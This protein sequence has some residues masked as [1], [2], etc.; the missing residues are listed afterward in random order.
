MIY[1]AHKCYILLAISM[2]MRK[3]GTLLRVNLSRESI[4]VENIPEYVM[5]AYPGGKALGYYIIAKEVSPSVSALSPENKLVFLPG[6]LSGLAPGASKVAVVSKSPE[7]HLLHDSYAGDRFGPFLKRWGYDAV[8]IEGRAKEL[9]YLQIGAEVKIKSA[10]E[11]SGMGLYSTTEQIWLKHG[12]GA[13]AAIGPGG[14]NLVKFA[15]IM[16][17]TERSAGRGGLGAVMGSKNLKAV[18]VEII[19][20]DNMK[21]APAEP[22]QWNKLRERLYD[23]LGTRAS[24]GLKMYGT[25]NALV[26]SGKHGMSPAYN[27]SRPYIDESLSKGLSG[28][29]VKQYEIA[30]ER[31]IH[32]ASC[33]VKCARYVELAHE[34]ERFRVKPEY[35]SLGMLGAATGVFEFEKVAYLIHLANDL[36][37]D[38]IAAGNVIG[39]L[40]EL[41]ERGDIGA[42]E[43]GIDCTGFGD[44]EAERKLLIYIAF[45]RGIGAVLAEGV[46]RAAEQLNRG[47]DIAVHVKGLEAPAWD[48]RGLRTYALSYATADVG[49]SHLR[50]WPS[51]RSLPNDGPAKELVKSLI[52]A[53]DKDAL[54][55]TLGICKF[56]PYELED[57]RAL[58]Y[59][60][61]GADID[62]NI[63]WRVET[64]SRL[65]AVLAGM[66]PMRDD[67]I[68]QRWW[69]PE[70]EGPAKGNA[71]FINMADF[72]EAK[73][74][75]YRLRE[76]SDKGV[77]TQD[78]LTMLHME[79][80]LPLLEQVNSMA[81]RWS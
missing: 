3:S 67:T 63:G 76:W 5:Q 40:F 57:I 58:Y 9:V 7:T 61:Y 79:E 33:P 70:P 53:R 17:D 44:A 55:D 68:P 77:P 20:L 21:L 73:A 24:P 50:G 25:T 19:A 37:L 10:E 41:V 4:T 81:E 16:F 23:L 52:D 78:T 14:E 2:P 48:P 46:M 6:A 27:F 45:R 59:S 56:V 26:S 43:L 75:F 8:V 54:F 69:E 65:Y 38:A 15:N 49:A 72:L 66:V 39:W 80:H 29:R 34:G 31:F 36:G 30:P 60:V 22:E 11:L 1:G 28:E 18:F 62:A 32:G 42:E 71:A 74:E 51:P 35:E 64:L 47:K 12:D 13:V